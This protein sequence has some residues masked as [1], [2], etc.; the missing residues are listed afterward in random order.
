MTTPVAEPVSPAAAIPDGSIV[1]AF[2][3]HPP[4]HATWPR[5]IA[6]AIWGFGYVGAGRAFLSLAVHRRSPFLGIFG[7][8]LFAAGIRIALNAVTQN[9]RP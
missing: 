1:D 8:A 2:S 7:V 3:T 4:A 6:I 5:R 9:R